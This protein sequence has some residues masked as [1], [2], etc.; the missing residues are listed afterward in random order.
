M[1]DDLDTFPREGRTRLMV[2]ADDEITSALAAFPTEEVDSPPPNDAVASA[3]YTPAFAQ[4]YP[5]IAPAA[6]PRWRR[7]APVALVVMFVLG[8]IAGQAIVKQLMVD[9]QQGPAEV[10]SV[11]TLAARSASARS[12]RSYACRCRPWPTGPAWSGRS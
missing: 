9:P 11:P 1:H 6:V 10:P 7:F 8:L 3:T 5:S 12:G 2:P 4:P